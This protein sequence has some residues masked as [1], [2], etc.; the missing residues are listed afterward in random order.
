MLKFTSVCVLLF[1]TSDS[2]KAKYMHYKFL[3][4]HVY[5]GDGDVA[6][7]ASTVMNAAMSMENEVREVRSLLE[8]LKEVY[9]VQ[10]AYD[11]TSQSEQAPVEGR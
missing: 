7:D 8:S 5:S 9:G 6:P 4:F 11:E 10:S 2:M 1:V 3:P